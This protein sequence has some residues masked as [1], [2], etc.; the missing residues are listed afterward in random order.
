MRNAVRDPFVVV[1]IEHLGDTNDQGQWKWIYTE[2]L[3]EAGAGADEVPGA[4]RPDLLES[5]HTR[6]RLK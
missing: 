6:V 2:A 3:S 1:G 4:L 5:N